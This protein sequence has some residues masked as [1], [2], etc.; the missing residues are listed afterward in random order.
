[1]GQELVKTMELAEPLA[2]SMGFE[3]LR[4]ETVGEASHRVLRIYLE[5]PDGVTAVTIDDCEKFSRALGTILDVE[6]QIAGRYHL[7]ISSPG[8]NRPLA[9]A[10]HFAAQIGKIIELTTEDPIQDRRHFKG[11]LIEV[12]DEKVIVLVVEGNHYEIPLDQ[13]KK[14]QLDYFAS[15]EKEKL[16]QQNLKKKR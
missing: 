6:G 3:I 1:M 8:L 15:E 16:A 9:K 14:A 4:S 10:K 13:V 11:D 12:R 7:E 2:A 5:K